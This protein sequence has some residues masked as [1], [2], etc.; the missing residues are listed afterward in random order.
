MASRPRSNK[1][2]GWPDGLYERG[3]YY[4]W[5]NPLT[6]KEMGIGRVPER[7]AKAQASEA[8]IAVQGLQD[9]PRLVDRLMGRE[10]TT[11]RAWLLKYEGLLADRKLA[12]STTKNYK[13]LVKQMR[14]VYAASLD[15]PLERVTTKIIADGITTIME[16]R[17]RTA[18]AMRSRLVD[19]FDRAAAAG[20]IQINPARITDEP[21]V[22]VRRARFTWEVF[23]KV[24][25]S[26][27]PGRIRNATALAL[28]SGQA[29]ET[30]VAGL[31]TDIGMVER[32]GIE[33]VEC[34][35]VIRGKTGAMIAIPVDLRLNVFGMSLRDVIKQC[36]KTN[37]ASKLLI[38]NTERPKSGPARIGGPV[39]LDTLSREFSDAV[40]ALGIDWGKKTAPTFHEIRS[41]SKRL[42]QTQGN[43]NTKDL[44]GHQTEQ[45]SDL[46]ADGR[47]VEYKLVNIGDRR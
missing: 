33:P 43:V 44:L 26:L 21:I 40:L 3:G 8:N 1:K 23:K 41:L 24:Y 25:D 15:L 22:T 39:A 42:Y 20:W 34:W 47:G 17:P 16:T 46:Y 6:G 11:F 31:F 45:M 10:D 13:A 29:R 2:R 14:I 19:S 5:R 7:E 18:Q 38:H 27:P 28:V 35:K 36:R 37:I 9:K 12:K 30:I 32:P 4:S